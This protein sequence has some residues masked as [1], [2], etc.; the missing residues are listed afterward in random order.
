M[1]RLSLILVFIALLSFS[2]SR[3]KI[4]SSDPKGADRFMALPDSLLPEVEVSDIAPDTNKPPYTYKI[5]NAQ[6]M[7]S[8]TFRKLGDGQNVYLNFRPPNS[9]GRLMLMPGFIIR[10]ED[11]ETYTPNRLS[12]YRASFP[13]YVYLKYNIE[14]DDRIIVFRSTVELEIEINEPGEWRINIYH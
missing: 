6:F 11:I 1:Y 10:S 5:L 2:C 4:Q 9:G 12:F 7:G 13:F 14:V 3:K 8:L